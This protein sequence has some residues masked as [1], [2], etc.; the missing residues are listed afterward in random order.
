M[1]KEINVVLMLL[2]DEGK[3]RLVQF[4]DWLFHYE[5]GMRLPSVSGAGAI[6]FEEMW[7]ERG[8]PIKD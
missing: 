2:S 8:V 1:I 3:E 4:A 6:D 7:K 5:Q